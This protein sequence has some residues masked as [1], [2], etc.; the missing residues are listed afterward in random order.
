MASENESTI[1]ELQAATTEVPSP[2]PHPATD[3]VLSTNKLLCGIIAHLPIKEILAAKR[4]CRT[5]RDSVAADP[6]IQQKLFLKPVKI[7]DVLVEDSVVLD[8]ENPIPIGKCTVICEVN[9]WISEICGVVWTGGSYWNGPH[10]GP[11]SHLYTNLEFIQRDG[12]WREMFVSQPPCKKIVVNLFTWMFRKESVTLERQAGVKMGELYDFINLE[13]SRSP[14][15]HASAAHIHGF[16]TEEY[17]DSR[18]YPFTRCKVR[19]GEVCRP[20]KLP[21]RP[22]YMDPDGLDDGGVS[23]DDEG[24][25]SADGPQEADASED[26]NGS[27]DPDDSQDSESDHSLDQSQGVIGYE[28]YKLDNDDDDDTDDYDDPDEFVEDEAGEADQYYRW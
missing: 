25:E 11:S 9:P 1:P 22:W 15:F 3:K 17:I 12:N 6:G 16:D 5:W 19:G 20:A 4:T 21:P 13:M 2:T 23:K 18:C 26:P 24:S 27:E 28:D 10:G 7:S 14:E 8:L